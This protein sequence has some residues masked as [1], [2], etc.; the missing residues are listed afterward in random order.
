M[1][2]PFP[3]EAPTNPTIPPQAQWRQPGPPVF[4]I[5]WLIVIEIDVTALEPTRF[6]VTVR[7]GQSPTS[8]EVIVTA[9]SLERFGAGASAERLVEESFHFLLEREPKESILSSFELPVIASYFP[10]YREE[11]RSRL[12]GLGGHGGPEAPG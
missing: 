12:G 8:H 10:E 3:Q 2:S 7:E 4:W 6:Q 5:T 9:E 11:I 1:A